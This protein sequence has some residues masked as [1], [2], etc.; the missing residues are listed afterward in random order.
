MS[1]IFNLYF[2]KYVLHG[3]PIGTVYSTK[4]GKT[5]YLQTVIV[6]LSCKF[7]GW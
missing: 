7:W 4:Y 6:E 3:S 2:L 5:I 1:L